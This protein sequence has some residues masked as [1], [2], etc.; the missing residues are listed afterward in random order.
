MLYVHIDES[1][2]GRDLRILV[3]QDIDGKQF[4]LTP[5]PMGALKVTP[6]QEGQRIKEDEIFLSLPAR[7]GR[8]FLQ[9]LVVELARLGYAAQDPHGTRVTEMQEHLKTLKQENEWKANVVN[10]LVD[11]TVKAPLVLSSIAE[12]RGGNS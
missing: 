4:A 11:A 7:V 12:T 1:N 6:M 2:F 5:A 10:K 9:G 8:E 3:T